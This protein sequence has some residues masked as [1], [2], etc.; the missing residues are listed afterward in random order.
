MAEVKFFADDMV[1][2]LAWWLRMIGY[3]T[4]YERQI[5]DDDLAA[6]AKDESR[7][8]LTRDTTFAD[9]Y[10]G[11]AVCFLPTDR[12]EV[13]LWLTVRQFGLD[14]EYAPFSRC[15]ACNEELVS[16]PKHAHRN[17]IP[18]HV[19]KT[20]DEF[21]YCKTCDQVFWHGSHHKNMQDKLQWLRRNLQRMDREQGARS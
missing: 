10:P 13:Q 11:I 18:P 1:G 17:K 12:P 14:M 4:R 20:L 7:I 21:W 16:V 15:L 8:V 6:I 5:E 2:R 9:R 19:F 3:D